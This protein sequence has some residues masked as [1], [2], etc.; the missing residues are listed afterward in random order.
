MLPWLPYRLSCEDKID[1][2]DNSGQANGG[3]HGDNKTNDQLNIN[4]NSNVLCYQPLPPS[5]CEDE[6]TTS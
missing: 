1:K 6:R 2:A 3:C 5:D 4:R